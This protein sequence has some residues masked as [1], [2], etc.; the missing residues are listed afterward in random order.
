MANPAAYVLSAQDGK[1][2]KGKQA[3]PPPSAVYHVVDVF[4]CSLDQVGLLEMGQLV[5]ATGGLMVLGDSFGQ[6]VF[7]ESLPCIFRRFEDDIPQDG[8]KLMMAFGAS[9]EVFT[10]REFKVAGTI[11]PVTPPNKHGLNVSELEVGR[12]GTSAWGLGGL[13]PSTTIAAYF[14]VTN[15]G[16]TPLVGR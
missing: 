7:K 5:E 16:N 12:G 11:G 6:S 14:Y 4:A 3:P 9:L 2:K 13:D 10:S 15:P 1:K 8:G